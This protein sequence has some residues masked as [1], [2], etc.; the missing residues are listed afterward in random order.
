MGL[1][2]IILLFLCV[3]QCPHNYAVGMDAS[4]IVLNTKAALKMAYFYGAA[5]GEPLTGEGKL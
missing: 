2:F 4:F 1:L 5:R 3:N